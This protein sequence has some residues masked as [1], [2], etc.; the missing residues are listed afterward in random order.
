LKTLESLTEAEW[1]E[2]RTTYNVSKVL[3][4][5]ASN[6]EELRLHRGR[7]VGMR[8]MGN[9][10]YEVQVNYDSFRRRLRSVHI[11]QFTLYSLY[12]ALAKIQLG[13][14]DE[15]RDKQWRI[16]RL[17]HGAKAAS[18]PT[19]RSLTQRHQT[20]HYPGCARTTKVRPCN[21]GSA[22]WCS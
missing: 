17:R 4:W 13:Q 14:L 5:R 2:I 9:G 19:W 12:R 7:P 21:L 20:G 16:L 10:T 22:I 3:I 8:L 1:T 15:E 11:D 6:A 18:R